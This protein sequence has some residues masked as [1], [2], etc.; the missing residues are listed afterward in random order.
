MEEK[1]P[2]PDTPERSCSELI[3]ACATLRD[4]VRKTSPHVVDEEVGEEIDSLVGKRGTRVR[5]GAA[6]NHLA[7]GERRR[8]AV[9]TTC[10]RE[11]G[12]PVHGGRRVGRRSGRG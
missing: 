5:R 10:L 9:D 3:G 4:A 12:P 11:N 7:G 2:L 1:D 6:G 8:V